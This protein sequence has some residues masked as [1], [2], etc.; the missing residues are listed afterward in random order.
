MH[1]P[2]PHDIREARLELKLSQAEAAQVVGVSE[3]T[4]LR[5]ETDPMFTSYEEINGAAWDTFLLATSESRPAGSRF[6]MRRSRI[7]PI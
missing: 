7:P 5:W 1:I 2:H 4:W 6:T 3:E